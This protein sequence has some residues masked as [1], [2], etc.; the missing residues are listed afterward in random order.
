MLYP[1]LSYILTKDKGE[2]LGLS[3]HSSL[4][5]LNR[6]NIFCVIPTLK[7]VSE[8]SSKPPKVFHP[9]SAHKTS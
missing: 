9:C 3:H 8:Q 5:T 1:T 4:N 2:N 6:S 7:S